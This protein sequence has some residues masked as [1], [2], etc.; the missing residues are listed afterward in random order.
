MADGQ[1]LMDVLKLEE[2]EVGLFR[3][4]QATTSRQRTFGGQVLAQAIVA[5]YRT[6]PQGRIMHSLN[7]YFLR[8]GRADSAIVYDVENT[9]DGGSFSARRVLARQGG[10]VIF[11]L[12]ASFHSPEGGLDHSDHAPEVPGPDE[13]PDLGELMV[14]RFGHGSEIWKEWTDLDLRYAGSGRGGE[15][16]PDAHPAQLRVWA[17]LRGGLPDEPWFHQ[18]ALAYLS[19]LTLLSVSTLPHDVV[20]T[21]EGLHAATIDHVMW[22]HRLVRADEWL[23]YDQVSPSASGGLGLANGRLFQ[24]GVL[25]ASCAQ[26][27]L[28]RLVRP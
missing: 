25:V 26:E 14:S 12:A 24:H 15:L 21:S 23:L 5:A 13:C 18:A 20:F 4:S 3:G 16:G 19:D 8:P 11:T 17:K 7:A 28:I 10:N 1:R 2:I 6:V 22:F 9:R 27:G